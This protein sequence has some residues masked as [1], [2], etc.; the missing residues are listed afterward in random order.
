M[1][2]RE[3]SAWLTL[4][5]IL[6][7]FTLYFAHGARPFVPDP[8][9]WSFHVLVMCIAALLVI[10]LVGHLVLWLRYREEAREPRDERELL[11]DLKATRLSAR[12][13]ALFTALAILTVHHGATARALG[14][15]IVFSF[16]LA[17]VVNYG[18][19]IYFYRRGS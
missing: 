9:P 5:A 15:F 10:E 4:L 19:R 17:Q 2:F 12:C 16:A 8:D 14:Y 18:A 1:S 13:Y 3:K 7:V 11:I 6:A